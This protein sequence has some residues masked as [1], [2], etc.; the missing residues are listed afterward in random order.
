MAIAVKRSFAPES[1]EHR[2]F[3]SSSVSFNMKLD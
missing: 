2:K 1:A 3:L